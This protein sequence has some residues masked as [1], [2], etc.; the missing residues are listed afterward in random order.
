MVILCVIMKTTG[1]LGGLLVKSIEINLE[2]YLFEFYKSVGEKAGLDTQQVIAD[3]LF[4]LAGELSLNA[5][6]AGRKGK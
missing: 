5:L 6:D 3:A 1:L 2:D 4:R